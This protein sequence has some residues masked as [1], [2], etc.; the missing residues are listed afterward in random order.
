MKRLVIVRHGK[1]VP[2][3]YENDF[4]RDLRDRGKNDAARISSEL[5]SRNILPD[6]IVSSPAKRAIKTARIFAKNLGYPSGKIQQ[7][8]GIYEGLTTDEFIDMIQKLPEEVSTAFF[9]GH[10]PGFY[11]YVAN[12]L[13]AFNGDM[14]TSSAVGIDFEG[15]SWKTVEARSGKMAFHLMPRLLK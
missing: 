8:P 5:K 11:Y 2:Y 3:G 4:E 7:E 12:L 10:N 13:S 14:P 1:A 9:F 6:L 15:N